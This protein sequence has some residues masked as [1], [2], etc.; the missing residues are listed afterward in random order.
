MDIN[1]ENALISVS[2]KENIVNFAK[3]LSEAGINIISSGGTSKKLLEEN[4]PVKTVEEITGFPEILEGRVKTLHPKIHGGILAKR[5]EKHLNE[6]KEKSIPKIDLVVVNLYP[7]HKIIEGGEEKIEQAIEQIDIGGHTLIRAA[8]KNFENIAVI[9]DPED[10]EKVADELVKKKSISIEMR[11]ML[12]AKAFAHA[13]HYDT[14]ISNYMGKLLSCSGERF[15]SDKFLHLEKVKDCRYGENPHQKAAVYRDAEAKSKNLSVFDAKQLHGKEIS[16]NNYADI[17]AAIDILKEFSET[18]VCIIKHTNTCGL[19]SH[20]NTETAFR[21]ALEGDP[22]SAF[23]GIIAMNENCSLGTA[24]QI[25]SFFNEIVIAPSYDESA[26]NELK[27]KKNLRILLLKE[28]KSKKI[29]EW[30]LKKLH[31]GF[32]IQE[33]D[34][35]DLDEDK[36]EIVS[37]KK[38]SED[39]MQAMRF[40]WKAVKHIKSNG[41]AIAKGKQLIGIGA[42]QTSRV[43]STLIAVQKSGEK[44]KGS[45]LASDAFFPFKDSIDTAAKHGIKAVIQPGGSI[46][47]REV[48]EAANEH[49]IILVFTGI[50]HF[51]H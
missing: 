7:F 2:N 23:G 8:A 18:T 11:K 39:D 24:K 19:A 51:K 5:N 34:L 36:L 10:Y 16:Y 29:E 21:L 15:A 44:V 25:T 35:I 30:E 9:V 46:K 50:R 49:G 6:L 38:P 47:D 26:L 1:I 31:G 20:E 41:I 13:A 43:D 28:L 12:A 14:I 48:I 45:V 40:A 22:V 42:G 3:K 32:L 4:L 17:N 33:K 27:K 37:E